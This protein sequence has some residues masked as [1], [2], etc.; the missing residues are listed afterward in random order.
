METSAQKENTQGRCGV[1]RRKEKQPNT[2]CVKCGKAANVLVYQSSFCKECFSEKIRKDFSFA[3]RTGLAH[4]FRASVRRVLVVLEDSF[5]SA[6]LRLLCERSMSQMIEFIYCTTDKDVE[7]AELLPGAER[8]GYKEKIECFKAY[9]AVHKC[10]CV[11][12]S[13]Y[14]AELA[15]SLLQLLREGK[16]SEFTPE[17][18]PEKNVSVLYPLSSVSHNA[19]MYYCYLEGLFSTCTPKREPL[20]G[21]KRADAE[22]IKSLLKESPVSIS[23]LV[24]TQQKITERLLRSR[25]S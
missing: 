15:C 20:C 3:L 10:E 9:A 14:S 22:L 2:I 7:R 17:V 19:F 25:S 4:T 18:S 21:V 5:S 24:K 16:I 11:V 23:N 6:M 1:R 12:L 8:M 13:G